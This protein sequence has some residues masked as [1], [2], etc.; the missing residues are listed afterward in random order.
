MRKLTAR[1]TETLRAGLA[2]PAG[3]AWRQR[4][5]APRLVVAAGGKQTVWNGEGPDYTMRD[6]ERFHEDEAARKFHLPADMSQWDGEGKDY[7]M[8][9]VEAFHQAQARAAAGPDVFN[10]EGPGAGQT[11]AVG[12]K[13]W[14][15]GGPASLPSRSMYNGEGQD[16]DMKDVERF[17]EEATK[18]AMMRRK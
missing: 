18:D 9:D 14:P 6:V 12:L 4:R 11:P 7:S 1:S 16:Y 10:G 5:P 3:A 17:H 15:H 2:R 13:A 8:K